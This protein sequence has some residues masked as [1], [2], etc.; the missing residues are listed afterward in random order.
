MVP[1]VPVVSIDD[2]DVELGDELGSKSADE[3]GDELGDA[4]PLRGDELADDS[5][6]L[7]VAVASWFEGIDEA[8]DIHDL[9]THWSCIVDAA[10]KAGRARMVG[11]KCEIGVATLYTGS[12]VAEK[13]L[14]DLS[15]E[16]GY[17]DIHVGFR[18]VY[19]CELDERKVEHLKKN[20]S[21]GIIYP[22]ADNFLN[23]PQTNMITGEPTFIPNDCFMLIAGFPCTSKTPLSSNAP[24]SAY[25][26]QT[27]EGKTGQGWKAVK[28]AIEHMLYNFV[29]L[30]NV[31]QLENDPQ[32]T[33]TSD[34]NTIISFLRSLGYW[35]RA[36]HVE[37]AEWGSFPYRHRIYI[38]AILGRP[39]DFGACI[40]L[41]RRVLNVLL[42]ILSHTVYGV[43]R[44]P[45]MCVCLLA[46]VTVNM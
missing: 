21:I 16:L 14:D 23:E 46:C 2:D 26:C 34:L 8:V 9:R 15:R 33:G 24:S 1:N 38:I 25:C 12:H 31:V 32:G 20:T 11:E 39:D 28:D 35:T 13:V 42:L 18:H 40:E 41:H 3:P 45:F 5:T 43:W 10:L 6:P 7:Q 27:Q 22:N 30:E 44:H 19:G 37:A 36:S 29:L 17:R 4:T